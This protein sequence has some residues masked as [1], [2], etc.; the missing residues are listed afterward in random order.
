MTVLASWRQRLSR[1]IER[2]DP[3]LGLVVGV[4]LSIVSAWAFAA[5]VKV[6][7]RA[8]DA[9][10]D[11]AFQLRPSIRESERIVMVDILDQTV[12]QLG[13]PVTRAHYG[14][15]VLALDRL[16]AQDVVFDVQFKT[17]AVRPEDF[18]PA[19]GDYR[20][21]PDS[22]VLRHAIGASG[23]VTLAYDFVLEDSLAPE[24]RR[25][26]PQ[27]LE[28]LRSDFTASEVL[29]ASRAG[30]DASLLA[31]ESYNVREEAAVVL[32]TELLEKDPS[33]PFARVREALLPGDLAASHPQELKILQFAYWTARGTALLAGK[34][35]PLRVEAMPPAA[36]TVHGIV[37]PFYPFLER[38]RAA[39]PVNA[40]ADDDG[41]LRR[42]W[43]ALWH[44][45]KPHLYLGLAGALGA[46]REVRIGADAVDIGGSPPLRL[47]VDREGRVLIDWAGNRARK[48]GKEEL[49]FAHLPFHALVSFYEDR[50]VLM[51]ENFRRFIARV[52]EDSGEPYHAEYAVLSD[53]LRRVLTGEVEMDP[54]EAR[55]VEAA[56][57]GHR[58]AIL[59]DL[60]GDLAGIE[61]ALP[62]ITAARAREN[63]EKELRRLRE[64]HAALR[65]GYDRE[66]QLRP[67][68][69]GRTCWIGSAST[70]SGD[71][72]STPLGATTPGI[73]AL[74]S[75]SNMVLTGQSL[76][77]A[78]GVLV[79]VWLLALGVA[80]S[81]AVTHWR[82]SWAA[83]A[84]LA[85]VAASLAIYGGLFAWGSF[86]LSGAGPPGTALLV[87]AGVTA[88][89]ELVT[90]RSRRKLEKELEKNTS[91]ELVGILMEHPEL[92][93]Q[94]R[95]MAGTFL[96]SDIKSFT[97]I[98]EK[99]TPEVLV[100]FI[101]RYLDRTT[102]SLKGH[103]AY[104]DKYIGDG[105]MAL[106]G[107]PVASGDHARNA[108]LA[109]LDN[110]AL[111][112]D[113][114]E[115]F[116][117]EGLPRILTR[118]GINSGEAIA[119]YVGAEERSDYT[120]L[121]D[122]V[123][124]ASRLEGANKEYGTSIMVSEF[125]RALVASQF[126]F[127]ELDRIRVVGKENAV[128]IYEL[129]A[130]AGSPIPFPD[131]FL[132]AYAAA[133]ALFRNRKWSEAVAAFEK[134]LAIRPGDRPSEVYVERAQAFLV[135]PPPPDWEGVFE[136]S[137]K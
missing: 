57:D 16:G 39:A 56:M 91:P 115:E 49:P 85:L 43:T 84:V 95:K 40:V 121:G 25:R 67:L 80:V 122:A 12:R 24:L 76:R 125:T 69:E 3:R 127:R 30:L 8:E 42:P 15:V 58:A 133:L 32:V 92:L 55:K 116:E 120:V 131:G 5:P 66:A 65:Q 98:S 41:V 6:A 60:A 1:A 68:V 63:S 79:A 74:A 134:A 37:P 2:G 103:Q 48:R 50:Y 19:T 28:V 38:A 97:S 59:A 83:A 31:R 27:L 94:P 90:E 136:L 34:G 96:F 137:S 44:R 86:L 71:L 29:L 104:L 118:I 72:H 99:M 18:D 51:D 17:T 4:L 126:V 14:Q 22:R 11:W 33:L 113:L 13:W 132:A 112:R 47:P 62:T 117:R 111:L 10:L 82:T 135:S 87:F 93:R 21:R 73:D 52:S 109:A 101:N 26:F 123:N 114:N 35:A 36:R 110:Q 100:P 81:F 75:V 107:V 89:K 78:P 54:A 64:L 88:F 45:G 53:R 124:L 128:G 61:K 9:V 77:E 20:I 7:R 108:C 105:I 46:G 70:A 102:R 106:F 130:P 119:G 23:K 129:V